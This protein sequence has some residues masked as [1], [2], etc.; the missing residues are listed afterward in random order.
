M[1]L[2]SDERNMQKELFDVT[3]V[4]RMIVMGDQRV[5]VASEPFGDGLV[6]IV[7]LH[8]F[9]EGI[10]GIT[11][12]KDLRS[13]IK[14][15]ESQGKLKG[16]VLDLRENSGGFLT[17]AV[18]VAGLFMSN[19]VVA[20]SKYG[21]GYTRYFRDLD[22]YSAYDGP[23]VILT[24]KASAS[25]AEI[26]AQTLQDYGRAL[27]VGDSRTYGKGSIQH[28]TV[29]RED[30][31]LFFKVTV[32]RYYTA[33]GASTQIS[34]VPADIVVPSIYYNEEI[35]EEFL[36]Y[37]LG[38]DKISASFHDPLS[39]INPEFRDW[40]EK[41]YVPTLQQPN[42]FWSRNMDTL[43]ANSRAR[44]EKNREFKELL[45]GKIPDSLFAKELASEETK[46]LDIQ[47]KEAVEIAK[48]MALLQ[49][50]QKVDGASIKLAEKGE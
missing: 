38:K 46:E 29:T 42:S 11:S 17:Q 47:V 41:Y 3:L 2:T 16:L 40:F 35:G 7:T 27:I 12:E 36:E 32:G 15:L 24:S 22:G 30:T 10:D 4:R 43:R 25:A 37:P 23:L 26:V 5:D 33:S 19:G 9:Y 44:I 49:L 45:G 13:A 8:S 48:D 39:D 21:N 18:K 28:Q 20:V 14:Q 6:G 50:E 1:R 31:D 34:G